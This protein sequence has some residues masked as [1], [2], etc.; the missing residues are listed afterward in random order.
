[1]EFPR[2][3]VAVKI[4]ILL[5]IFGILFVTFLSLFY[6]KKDSYLSK[7]LTPSSKLAYGKGI[8]Y[9][10]YH[11]DKKVCSV[12]INSFSV[13]RARLGPFAIGPLHIARLNKVTVDLYLDGMDSRLENI[14]EKILESGKIDFEHLISNIKKNLSIQIKKIKGIKIDKISLNL[15]ENEKRVFRISSD[16]ATVDHKTGDLIFTGHA[17]MDAGQNGK[18]QSYR[19]RWERKTRLFKV[20]D[21]F[22]LIKDGKRMEGKG[23]ETDCL[24]KRINYQVSNNK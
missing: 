10:E 3:R 24:L 1:M 14:K 9:V 18:L 5:S 11:G 4:L 6:G 13:E 8:S 12:S 2:K 7:E 21:P 16:T 17:I 19:I 15:W 20:I 23:I 22:Y